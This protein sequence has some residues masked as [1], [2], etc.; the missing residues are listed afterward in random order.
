VDPGNR[1]T[2]Q[3]AAA[4]GGYVPTSKTVFSLGSVLISDIFGEKLGDEMETI[5]IE[6]PP[7]N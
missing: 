5:E 3:R 1:S 2:G 4:S 7:G 6:Y